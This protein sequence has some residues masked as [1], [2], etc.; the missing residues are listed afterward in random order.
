[1]CSFNNYV[2]RA[3][4]AARSGTVLGLGRQQGPRQYSKWKKLTVPGGCLGSHSSC[5]NAL[6]K[7]LLL[8]NQFPPVNSENRHTHLVGLY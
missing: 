4:P 8:M 6:G 3:H 1:M 7:F 5:L 2:L